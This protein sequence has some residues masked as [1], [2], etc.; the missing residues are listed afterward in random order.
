MNITY[1]KTRLGFELAHTLE[2]MI[3]YYNLGIQLC[4]TVKG[5]NIL[6]K[7]LGRIK[8]IH[9]DLTAI[10]NYETIIFDISDCDNSAKNLMHSQLFHEQ[11]NKIHNQRRLK[12]RKLNAAS[13]KKQ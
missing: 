13:T 12:G 5:K 9:K 2:Y 8:L 4:K 3:K 6:T 7:E 11:I 10:S 1:K